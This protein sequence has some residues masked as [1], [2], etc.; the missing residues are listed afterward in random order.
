MAK[1]TNKTTITRTNVSSIACKEEL[2]KALQ[3]IEIGAE[4]QAYLKSILASIEA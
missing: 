1:N 3:P 2:H 4:N